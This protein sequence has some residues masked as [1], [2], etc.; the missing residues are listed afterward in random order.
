MTTLKFKD[1]EKMNI[2][3]RNK[4]MQEMK[5]EL[6]KA[7]TNAAKSGTS[8]AK[9]IKKIIARILTLNTKENKL[10]GEKNK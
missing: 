8:K 1:L 3:E 10:V 7:K 4:K 5:Y 2:E 9:E 6:V